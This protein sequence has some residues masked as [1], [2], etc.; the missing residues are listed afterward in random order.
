MPY[1]PGNEKKGRYR[2]DMSSSS[3][4]DNELDHQHENEKG[5]ELLFAC[6]SEDS[7]NL[8][9]NTWRSTDCR[10]TQLKNF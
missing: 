2:I 10:D 3:A 8:A 6:K 9:W 7:N 5:D 4:T 1:Y